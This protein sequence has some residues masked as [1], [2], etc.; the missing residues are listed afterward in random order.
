MIA[1]IRLA[2]FKSTR[3]AD[4]GLYVD[5]FLGKTVGCK[6]TNTFNLI[7]FWYFSEQ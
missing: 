7:T 6:P 4:V 2:Y 3:W 1:S 5:V